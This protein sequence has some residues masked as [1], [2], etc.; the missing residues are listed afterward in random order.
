MAAKRADKDKDS[1][2]SPLIKFHHTAN[3]QQNAQHINNTHKSQ[4]KTGEGHQV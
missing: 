2:Y 3:G 1:Q 4:V